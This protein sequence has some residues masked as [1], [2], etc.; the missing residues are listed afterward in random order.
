[1]FDFARSL[2]F[3]PGSRPDRFSKALN[4]GA[5]LTCIDLEDAVAPQDKASARHAATTFLDATDQLCGVRINAVETRTGLDDL[6]A[7]VHAETKPQF[8]MLPKIEKL[9]FVELVSQWLGNTIPLVPIIESARGLLAAA[10]VFSH[11]QVKIALFGGADYSADVGC[12]LSWEGLYAART[13]LLNAAASHQVTLFDVPYIDV[14]DLAGLADELQRCKALGMRARSAIH[15]TQ[16]E[17]IHQALAPSPAEV[18]EAQNVVQAFATAKGGAALLNGKLIE[19][20]VLKA[21][22][23]TLDR[24][25]GA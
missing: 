10:T 19:L 14:K 1:M 17:V 2:L 6:Q 8:V 7:L 5:D 3:V 16:I 25:A 11:P 9:E 4:A 24:F 18:E 23:R 21:A 15:P 13:T 12:D 22:Q 20:P